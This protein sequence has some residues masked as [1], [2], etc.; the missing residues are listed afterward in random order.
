[1]FDRGNKDIRSLRSFSLYSKKEKKKKEKRGGKKGRK[2]EGKK[3]SKEIQC[4]ACVRG[5]GDLFPPSRA[6]KGSKNERGIS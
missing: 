1:M 2:R 4:D 6:R 5:A 3:R